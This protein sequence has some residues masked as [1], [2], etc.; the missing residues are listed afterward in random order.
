MPIWV[1]LF[2]GGLIVGAISIQHPYVWGNGGDALRLILTT[3]WV[4]TSLLI[5]L[6][7]KLVA[8]F[9]TVG[10]GAVGGVFTPTLLV[11]A[12][13]GFLFGVPV[14]ALLPGFTADPHSYAV[15]LPRS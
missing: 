9:A 13:I 6:F 14:K 12:A 15:I 11:G 10:S 5:L 2:G 3:D 7:F 8:T 1:R 4:W